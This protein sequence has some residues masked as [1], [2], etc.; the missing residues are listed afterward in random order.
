MRIEKSRKED[1]EHWSVLFTYAEMIA[2]MEKKQA[3]KDNPLNI[4]QKDISIYGALPLNVL[5]IDEKVLV[6][7]EGSMKTK[8]RTR[9]GYTIDEKTNKKIRISK[10]SNEKID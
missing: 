2:A 5:P 4:E 8:K 9:I 1:P 3:K 7:N 10:K 6:R